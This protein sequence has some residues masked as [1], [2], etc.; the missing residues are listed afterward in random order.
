[1]LYPLNKVILLLI[2]LALL[3]TRES[4]ALKNGSQLYD[5]ALR[6]ID[7]LPPIYLGLKPVYDD[8]TID[9]NLYIP[10]YN[11]DLKAYEVNLEYNDYSKTADFGEK[12][13]PLLERAAELNHVDSIVSLAD[14]YMFGNYSTPTNYSKALEYYHKAI[15]IEG[16]GNA[17]F[18]LGFLYS[19][20]AFGEIPIDEQKGNLYYQFGAENNN[21]NAILAL[22]SKYLNG[23]GKPTNCNMARYYY[24]RLAHIGMQHM[25]QSNTQPDEHDVKY[26]LKL[27][28]FNGGIYGPKL[29]ESPSSVFKRSFTSSKNNFNELTLDIHDHDYVDYFFTALELYYGDYF[30]EKNHT[31]AFNKAQECV[32][33]AEL[34]FSP[35]KYLNVNS[36]DR[37]FISRCQTLLATLYFEGH[38]TERDLEKAHHWFESAVTLDK[39]AADALNSLAVLYQMGPLV[40]DSVSE[41]ATQ[42]LEQALKLLSPK[43]AFSIAKRG[44][45]DYENSFNVSKSDFE[46]IYK[47]VQESAYSGNTEALYYWLNFINS[48]VC[49]QYGHIFSCENEVTFYKIFIEKLEKFFFPHLEYAFNEFKYGNF[50][51]SLL[52]YLIAAEQGLENAQVS[53]AYILFQLEPLLPIKAKKTFTRSR[54]SAAIKYLDRAS[55]QNNVDATILLGD[56]NF[57]GIPS[58]NVSIDY[59]KAFAYYNKAAQAHSSHGAFNLGYMYEYG[60]GPVN[61]SVDYFMAKRYYDS[62]LELKKQ[63]SLVSK[64]KDNSKV[65]TVPINLALLRLRLKFLFNKKKYSAQS[66]IADGS[67][68][69]S[70]FR[71]LGNDKKEEVATNDEQTSSK[72]ANNHAKAQTHHEGTSYFVDE[73]YDAGD[74]LV[75]FFTFMFFAVF[76]VQNIYRH[77]RNIGQRRNENNENEQDN[78]APP[79]N[80]GVHFEFHFVAL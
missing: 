71:K 54:M 37:F 77:V 23:V 12:A 29:S 38:G 49:E 31:K 33:I 44:L 51:N 62:S 30:I 15:S 36:V 40:R 68:W 20:G 45:L 7:S 26:N 58:A 18:M 53:A 27:V 78:Q 11:E 48:G 4:F 74:Y 56:I 14:I 34:R 69:L 65:N 6:I 1:M 64:T 21:V 47:L 9:N 8:E 17:Y 61:N 2:S 55:S 35:K 66:D 57:N 19:T 76:I 59:N 41:Y 3:L 24:A 70:A 13:I 52:G 22:A 10:Q 5:D 39:E 63:I 79:A 60:L 43:A 42:Y 72:Q 73:V 25:H 16:N 46:T 28:D 75:M 80:R 32:N 50:K 67:S